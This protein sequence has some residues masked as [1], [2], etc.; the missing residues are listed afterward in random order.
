MSGAPVGESI[1]ISLN[2]KEQSFHIKPNV[3]SDATLSA[4]HR[5]HKQ[6]ARERRK[7][8]LKDLSDLKGQV[9]EGCYSTFQE[10]L[11]RNWVAPD[12]GGYLEAVNLLK[13]REGM[14]VALMM[15]CDEIKTYDQAVSVISSCDSVID[16][17]T[18]LF[19]SG[20]EALESA[21]NS[22]PPREKDPRS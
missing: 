17:F 22:S 3:F 16:L 7:E 21:K 14:A 13:T 9:D 18:V 8:A 10:E 1:T 4:L 12:F 19:Q 6:Q 11:V 5:L 2:G 20:N 15:N